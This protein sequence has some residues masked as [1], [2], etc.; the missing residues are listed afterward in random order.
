MALVLPSILLKLLSDEH[1]V[2]ITGDHFLSGLVAH[3]PTAVRETQ[4]SQ[5]QWAQEMT[6]SQI[7]ACT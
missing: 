4:P 1:Q 7:P 5:L 2:A 3:W 6:G